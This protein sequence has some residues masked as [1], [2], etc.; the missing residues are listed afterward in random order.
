MSEAHP[1]RGE[2]GEEMRCLSGIVVGGEE[3]REAWRREKEMKRCRVAGEENQG[4]RWR[5]DEGIKR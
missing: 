3:N 2:S 1:V 4:R 5:Q